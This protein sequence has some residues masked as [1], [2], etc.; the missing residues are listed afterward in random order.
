VDGKI[1]EIPKALQDMSDERVAN[2]IRAWR[3]VDDA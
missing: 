1:Y 2:F 3:P